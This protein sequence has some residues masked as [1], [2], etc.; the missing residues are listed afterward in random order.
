M[1]LHVGLQKL[2]WVSLDAFLNDKQRVFVKL[3]V[4]WV[5]KYVWCLCERDHLDVHHERM[6]VL[7]PLIAFIRVQFLYLFNGHA[8]S[9]KR[10]CKQ[11]HIVV[12]ELHGLLQLVVS[13]Y[14]VVVRLCLL[15][16]FVW[17]FVVVPVP[18]DRIISLIQFN[19]QD[20][21]LFLHFR[22]LFVSEAC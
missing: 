22:P 9:N 17:Y 2:L 10:V 14:V 13:D 21:F 20:Q 4:V 18:L 12:R 16:G 3:E 11:R 5:R 1:S 19:K 6:K 7:K 15:H 8:I